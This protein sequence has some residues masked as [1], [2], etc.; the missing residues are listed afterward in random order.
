MRTVGV[1]SGL[2]P[3]SYMESMG[4]GVSNPSSSARI[5]MDKTHAPFVM[6]RYG[7]MAEMDRS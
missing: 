1:V 6:E 7:R 2:K 3:L 5:D 4:Y